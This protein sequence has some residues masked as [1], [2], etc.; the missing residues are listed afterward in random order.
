[1][2]IK[3]RSNWGIELGVAELQT[4]ESNFDLLVPSPCIETTNLKFDL[5]SFYS[6]LHCFGCNLKFSM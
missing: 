1:M 5:F 3:F 2:R 6:Y 4:Q